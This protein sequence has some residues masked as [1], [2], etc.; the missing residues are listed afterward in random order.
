MAASARLEQHV[1][2]GSEER[3]RL[4]HLGGHHFRQAFQAQSRLQRK[5]TAQSSA[6]RERRSKGAH[7][8]AA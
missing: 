6:A 4:E 1:V 8:R 3:V 2:K 7:R 5:A